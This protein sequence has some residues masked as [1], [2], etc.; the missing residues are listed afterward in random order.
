M[1]HEDTADAPRS[2]EGLRPIA[3][4]VPLRPPQALT[5]APASTP[6]PA[7]PRH[8]SRR[9]QSIDLARGFAV[10]LMIL[11]H[12]VNGLLRFDQFTSWGLVPIHALT[13]FSSSLFFIVFGIA[14][15]V[16]YVP[17]IGTSDWP[18]RR[19]QLLERGLI[20]LFWY[21]VLTIVE[22]QQL[23]RPSEVIDALLYR[24]FPS[25]VEILGFYAIALLWVPF[26][27]PLWA[28]LSSLGR[29]LLPAATVLVAWLV[30]A[31]VPFRSEP[32]QALLVEHPDHYTWGQLT[33]APLVFLGLALGG[34]IRARRG[35][36]RAVRR[37]ALGVALAGSALLL[38]FRWQ[39]NG[40]LAAELH[41]V[42][43]NVG[44]HPPELAFMC[45]SVGGA[46]LL[47]GL[48]LAGGQGLAR[49][50]SLVTVIGSDALQAFIFHIT[51]IFLLL[52]TW[53]GYLHTVSY[54]VALA[55]TVA[56]TFATAG[57][58][59]L[60]AFLRNAGRSRK[61]AS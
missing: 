42:A 6:A 33:R 47:L 26:A 61:A 57:W 12:G 7:D 8:A 3:A 51:V 49:R 5:G 28:R 58:I 4:P 41:A 31:L 10:C 1:N 27:L 56:L 2:S 16:A 25:Y 32:L 35:D 22:M 54:A 50:L 38:A 44:K 36:V 43:L 9:I 46:L 15:A 29:W 20:V 53:L 52:R 40:T 48:A 24:R 19:K 39:T 34:M 37:V 45:F 55:L 14:L 17:K 30:A 18:E 23:H 13:K 59:R 60:Y 21:K 11:S